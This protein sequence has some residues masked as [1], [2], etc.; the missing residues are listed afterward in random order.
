M[1]EPLA[2][3]AASKRITLAAALHFM[4]T[5][6]TRIRANDAEI[7]ARQIADF[8][9]AIIPK[10]SDLAVLPMNDFGQDIR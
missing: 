2:M 3:I 7:I 5:G 6:K 8:G 4:R 9:L 1:T 10:F